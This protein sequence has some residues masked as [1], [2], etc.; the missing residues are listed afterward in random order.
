MSDYS[1]NSQTWQPVVERYLQACFDDHKMQREA[2]LSNMMARFFR[3]FG[4]DSV[5]QRYQICAET[6][7]DTLLPP[8]PSSEWIVVSNSDSEIVVEI[9]VD[10]DAVSY[11]NRVPFTSTRLVLIPDNADWC[12]T[13]VWHPCIGCSMSRRQKSKSVGQCMMCNG[14]GNLSPIADKSCN[15]CEGTGECPK[16][17]DGPAIGWRR[18]SFLLERP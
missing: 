1:L 17:K 16:C 6:I 13:D 3:D 5:A 18:A 7:R 12:V 9:S 11:S 8:P 10:S 15:H 14:A 2:K 4:T